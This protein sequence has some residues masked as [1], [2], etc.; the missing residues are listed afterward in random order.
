M[1]HEGMAHGAVWPE[2]SQR[3]CATGPLNA[4][5]TEQLSMLCKPLFLQAY[6]GFQ[7]PLM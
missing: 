1:W 6:R 4:D 3:G 7:H 5:K 2:K